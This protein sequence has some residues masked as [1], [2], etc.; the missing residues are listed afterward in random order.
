[1]ELS[2]KDILVLGD[3]PSEADILQGRGFKDR[4]SRFMFWAIASGGI[5]WSNMNFVHF[6]NDEA[7]WQDRN[8][9]FNFKLLDEKIAI[10]KPKV[11]VLLGE[12]IM[13]TILGETKIEKFRG[14]VMDW[15]RNDT[16]YWVI[17]TYDQRI[18]SDKRWSKVGKGDATRCCMF[19]ND[20]RKSVFISESGWERPKENFQLDP[21]IEEVEKFV[22]WAIKE[23]PLLYGDIEGT[24]LNL[25]RSE[26][27]VLGLAWSESE[28]IVIPFKKYGG[29]SA[30]NFDEMMRLKIAIQKLFDQCKGIIWQ[31]GANYDIPVLNNEFNKFDLKHRA[32][33][34]DTMLLH[35]TINPE[36]KHDIG[37]INSVYGKLPY[38]KDSFITKKEHI[39][40]TDQHNMRLYNARDCVALVPMY[41]AMLKEAKDK[42]LYDLY[43]E[44]IDLT[45]IVV[46]MSQ[47]GLNV[48]PKRLKELREWLTT[49]CIAKEKSFRELS[50]VPEEL[51]VGSIDDMRRVWFGKSS[52]KA[53]KSIEGAWKYEAWTQHGGT[54]NECGSIKW[55]TQDESKSI[56]ENEVL[57]NGIESKCRKCKIRTW[58]KP[59]KTKEGKL[60]SKETK[61]YK[62]IQGILEI[63]KYNPPY[64]LRTFK[65]RQ[66]DGG[67]SQIDAKFRESYSIALIKRLSSIEGLKAWQD[68][69]SSG[70]K[71]H[72]MEEHANINKMLELIKS[73][74][75]FA[76]IKK[77]KESYYYWETRDDGRV[78][79]NIKVTGTATGR[80]SSSKP[81]LFTFPQSQK[82]PLLRKIFTPKEGHVFLSCDYKGLENYVMAYVTKD[83]G[84][85]DIINNNLDL[86]DENTKSLFGLEPDDPKFNLFRKAA[87]IFQFAGLAYGGGDKEIHGN[88]TTKHPETK[89]TLKKYKE[90]KE[91]YMKAHPQ[92][93][94]W[95]DEIVEQANNKRYVETYV[96]GRRR[97][98]YGNVSDI[99][100]EAMNTPI[101]GTAADIV[102]RAMIRIHRRLRERN[103]KTELVL[104]V[105]DELNYEVPL[106]ELPEVYKI[107]VEE[108]TRPVTIKGIERLFKI[109][110]E[111]GYSLGELGAFDPETF[112]IIGDSKH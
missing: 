77:L 7:D 31:H 78:H 107:V 103:L 72:F 96:S 26:V 53:L 108:M 71:K 86:H 51:N 109:D 43:L 102:N 88:I 37:F 101:Q 27:V 110:P 4:D 34:G 24:G 32:F 68:D 30:F 29:V 98:L 104:Y 54:C 12:K 35:H 40:Y 56:S 6:W 65:P 13:D 20:M 36:L 89:L 16:T 48:D 49:E 11:I 38:W 23:Q 44:Q 60:K 3:Y 74:N 84:L 91:S 93:R 1:M 85:L 28:A 70:R 17:P 81:N 41:E 46:R 10:I 100:K 5:S 69:P 62:K 99:R 92:Y 21:T 94:A 73:Y 57:L 8:L 52:A 111:I 18:L 55:F 63:E 59:N 61:D 97:Y 9:D 39:Y 19:Q 79:S 105:Y 95:V 82:C 2:Q 112:E 80:F 75:E 47:V 15:T 22:D 83:R 14:S 90:A 58:H 50:G 42:G 106:S 66:T 76:S 45:E 64:I 67:D 33:G 25:N 87:K